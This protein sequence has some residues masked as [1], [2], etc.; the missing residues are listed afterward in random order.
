MK[1]KKQKK[2]KQTGDLLTLTLNRLRRLDQK[3][4][5]YIESQEELIAAQNG[6][7]ARY[8]RSFKKLRAAVEDSS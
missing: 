3:K 8:R 1:T 4:D 2:K 6:V 5:R 7:I